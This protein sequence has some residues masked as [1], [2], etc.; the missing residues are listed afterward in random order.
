MKEVKNSHES[1]KEAALCCHNEN[2]DFCCWIA[3]HQNDSE[4]LAE[5]IMDKGLPDGTRAYLKA[6]VDQ[7]STQLVVSSAMLP[8]QA[9]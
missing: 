7:S 8:A 5:L 3:R 9:S 4:K 6:C 2:T 1:S